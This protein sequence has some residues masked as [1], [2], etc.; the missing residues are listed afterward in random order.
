MRDGAG[1]AASLK[2]GCRRMPGQSDFREWR[3]PETAD[4]YVRAARATSASGGTPRRPDTS[5]GD[6]GLSC[7]RYG[8]SHERVQS[9]AAFGRE[10]RPAQPPGL[11]RRAGVVMVAPCA[12]SPYSDPRSG[13]SR[14]Q[15][16]SPGLADSVRL[17]REPFSHIIP[18]ASPAAAFACSRA[19]AHAEGNRKM[20][21]R[22]GNRE[23]RK[24]KQIKDRKVEAAS[25]VSQLARPALL[26]RRG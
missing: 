13:S 7:S 20:A 21:K 18:F 23:A 24:P 11:T 19:L 1:F 17:A 8:H 12:R 26:G 25:T 4:G 10:M 16:A 15:A 2:R 5:Y 14:R 3:I 9:D 6:L 22:N